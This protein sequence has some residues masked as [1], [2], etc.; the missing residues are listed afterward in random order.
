VVGE[1]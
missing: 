1:G